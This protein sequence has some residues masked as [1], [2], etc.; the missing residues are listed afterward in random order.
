MPAAGAPA[1]ADTPFSACAILSSGVA[2]LAVEVVVSL[3]TADG[4]GKHVMS[5]GG[6][7]LEILCF[8]HPATGGT[9]YAV[10][11]AEAVTFLAGDADGQQRCADI[12]LTDDTLVECAE[13]FTVSLALVTD[14]PNLSLGAADTTTVTIADSDSTQ[15]QHP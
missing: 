15:I 12:A 14:K 13:D 9:D 3:T 6:G 2:S 10:L 5:S 4:T 8:L 11:A 7:L 1:E